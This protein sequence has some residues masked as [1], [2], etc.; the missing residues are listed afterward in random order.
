MEQKTK[1]YAAF[2]D[3]DFTVLSVNSGP[4]VV[5][6]AYRKGMMGT[7]SILNAILQ[8][9]LYKFNLRD[10]NVIISKMGLW[11][12][13]IND[14]TLIKLSG[15]VVEKYLKPAVRHEIIR[16]IAFHRENHGEIVILS[17]VI[18]SISKPLGKY[19]EADCVLCSEMEVKDG[20]LTGYPVGKFCFGEEKRE[21]LISFCKERN[22]IPS[23]SWYYAD[24]ISDM[25]AFEA[26]GHQVCVSPDRKLAYVAS[27]RGWKVMRWK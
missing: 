19:L 9:Y 15:E 8:G 27:K 10:T 18:S 4:I 24:S 6:E 2:F 17:S 22:Y 1:K 16:E 13:G 25:E 5:R 12:K 21:R 11:L 7:G 26:V 3:L 14:E 20:F 23:E